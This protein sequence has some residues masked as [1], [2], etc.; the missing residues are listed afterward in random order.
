MANNKNGND[1]KG[2][3]SGNQSGSKT[4]KNKEVTCGKRSGKITRKE[5]VAASKAAGLVPDFTPKKKVVTIEQVQVIN[6]EPSAT[7]K[8]IYD[9]SRL[10]LIRLNGVTFRVSMEK[11][12]GPEVIAVRVHLALS[13]TELAN[14]AGNKTFVTIGQLHSPCFRT[15]LTDPDSINV[16]LRIY[17]FLRKVFEVEGLLFAPKQ[18][19]VAE[20][21]ENFKTLPLNLL[22]SARNGFYDF[23]EGENKLVV[24]LFKGKEDYRLEVAQINGEHPLTKS[25]IEVGFSIPSGQFYKNGVYDEKAN[26]FIAHLRGILVAQQVLPAPKKATKKPKE[27]I[28]AESQIAVAS[29]FKDLPPGGEIVTNGRGI[30]GRCHS[31]RSTHQ[32]V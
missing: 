29:Q 14:L 18:K 25:N 24:K 3:K 17:N 30:Y 9:G 8:I 23:K 10:G 26:A 21:V 20:K 7:A 19:V 13:N 32:K 15:K 2:K 22:M 5:K 16:Q 4:D 31:S 11:T 27:A 12:N 6:G 1:N 28:P